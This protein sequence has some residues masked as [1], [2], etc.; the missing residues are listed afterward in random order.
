MN[1]EEYNFK[2][3]AKE[4]FKFFLDEEDVLHLNIRFEKELI[5]CFTLSDDETKELMEYLIRVN[6]TQPTR[7]N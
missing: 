2:N 5:A 4:E 7:R 1:N 6:E 3:N